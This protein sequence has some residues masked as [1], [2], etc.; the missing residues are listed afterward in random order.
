[1]TVQQPSNRTF[2]TVEGLSFCGEF[3]REAEKYCFVP[4]E[5]CS[6]EHTVKQ[7]DNFDLS[8]IGLCKFIGTVNHLRWVES[9]RR[10][11]PSVTFVRAKAPPILVA[12]VENWVQIGRAHV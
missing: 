1:M 4:V 11:L 3:H 7:E 5:L 6:L 9:A 8:C 10:G 2:L 12:A